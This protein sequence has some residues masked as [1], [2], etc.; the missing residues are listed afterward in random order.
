MTWK[1]ENGGL[2]ISAH[3]L[4]WIV[5]IMFMAGGAFVTFATKA[6][7][8]SRDNSVT[9]KVHKDLLQ[10]RTEREADMKEIRAMQTEVLRVLYEAQNKKR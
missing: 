4:I 8:E 1:S 2:K 9:E 3:L 6:D 5:G 7:V 10:E